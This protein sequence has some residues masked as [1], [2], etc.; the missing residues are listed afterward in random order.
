MKMVHI[1]QQANPIGHVPLC[2]LRGQLAA[3]I[4]TLVPGPERSNN[5]QSQSQKL[6]HLQIAR[7]KW[8]N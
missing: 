5:A 7:G 4:S 2:A 1:N 8:E 3:A 6:C